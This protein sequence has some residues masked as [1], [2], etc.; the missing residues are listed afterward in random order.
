MAIIPTILGEFI[1]L[2]LLISIL[3]I[4]FSIKDA[5][6]VKMLTKDEKRDVLIM[7]WNYAGVIGIAKWL[8][9]YF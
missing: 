1:G 9:S 8:S 4:A 5:Q 2:T 7:F 6:K 3:I